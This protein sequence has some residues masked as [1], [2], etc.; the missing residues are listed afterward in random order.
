MTGNPTL[1][2]YCMQTCP[3][4]FSYSYPSGSTT[5]LPANG[6]I[7]IHIVF[8]TNTSATP[9][10][11]NFQYWATLSGWVLQ[12]NIA[13]VVTAKPNTPSMTLT[14]ATNA[15]SVAQGNPVTV[16]LTLTSV[17]GMTGNPTITLYCSVT[18]PTGFAY[19]YTYGS[20]RTLAANGTIPIFATFT[21]SSSSPLGVS[22]F[23]YYA[24]LNGLTVTATI[25]ITVTAPAT[26]T[27]TVVV[28]TN[29]TVPSVSCTLNGVSFT[30]P[31]H[32]EQSGGWSQDAGMHGSLGI[33]SHLDSRLPQVRLCLLAERLP[34][35][36]T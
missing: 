12:A 23:V 7:P 21:P 11:Y 33:H 25:A 34:L 22:N 19:N 13:V 8:G 18:C 24:V 26:N 3:A 9:G 2:L 29:G 5:N 16:N 14:P 15:V 31:T 28:M 1:Q 4:N 36:S 17:N 10:T 32:S 30:G 6:T 27:G 20:T 35:P